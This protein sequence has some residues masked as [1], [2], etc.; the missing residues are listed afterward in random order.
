MTG[1]IEK[2][3]F[4]SYRRTNLPWA[5]AIYQDL[6]AH[7]YDAFFDFQSINSGDFS[8]IILENIKARAHFILLL[9]PSALEHCEDPN[10]WLRREIETAIDE[11][12]NI[13]PVM[14]E[15]F[16]F[17][18]A[19]KYLTGKLASLKNYNGLRIHADY[20]EE[21]LT[22]LRERYLS[23]PLDLVLHPIS[24]SIQ[25]ATRE[26]QDIA[27][28]S[29]KVNQ[30]EF[31]VQ[32]WIEKGNEQYENQ[33]YSGAIMSYTEAIRQKP[34]LALAHHLR[35]KA[36][37]RRGNYEN[38]IVDSTYALRL[39]PDFPEAYINLGSARRAQN[40]PDGAIKEFTEAIRLKPDFATAYNNRGNARR[41]KG[42]LNGAI[43]DYSEAIRLRPDYALA[44][45]N[46]GIVRS[47]KG[48]FDGA[49][50]DCNEA[51]RIKPDY[52]F[53][54]IYRAIAL[55]EK[56]D[57]NS[58]IKDCTRAI[59]LKPDCAEAFNT[60]GNARRETGDVD[61]AIK[62]YSEAVR[63][64]PD[65]ANAFHNRAF[66]LRVQGDPEGAIRDYSKAI[67]LEPDYPESYLNRGISWDEDKKNYYLAIADYQM[68]LDLGGDRKEVT[69]WI[70]ELKKKIR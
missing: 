15:S 50:E 4:I 18:I 5:R 14:L 43:R 60:R 33:D 32:K 16:D 25:E 64:K 3:V 22:R 46:R 67:R 29:E 37:E 10:D 62:D 28:K 47:A 1:R 48:D 12:R 40:D 27:N 42:D 49:I 53:A 63:L 66:A 35:G 8:Q 44:F 52:V 26:Q 68:Y 17:G 23:I 30:I 70:R 19:S 34:D 51:I 55:Y 58:A 57:F 45:R 7:G 65:Y 56:G 39:Q 41:D 54:F 20:F 13:I 31:D 69:D 6:T 2:T 11:K 59:R 36:F 61:G 21:G 38:A 9:T 24:T